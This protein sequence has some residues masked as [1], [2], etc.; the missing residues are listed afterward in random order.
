MYSW[1]NSAC[2][3]VTAWC[4]CHSYLELPVWLSQGDRE[5]PSNPL[6]SPAFSGTRVTLQMLFATRRRRF[7]TMFL[8]T[9]CFTCMRMWNLCSS[10]ACVHF[11][12]N[13]PFF[14]HL[15]NFTLILWMFSSQCLQVSRSSR[16]L[17][18]GGHKYCFDITN[19]PRIQAQAIFTLW[20]VKGKYYSAQWSST[21]GGKSP[22]WSTADVGG[23]EKSFGKT[24]RLSWRERELFISPNMCGANCSSG[25]LMVTLSGVF[26]LPSASGSEETSAH[27]L[28]VFMMHTRWD[29][30]KN[31]NSNNY[32]CIRVCWRIHKSPRS[33]GEFA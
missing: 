15:D 22:E 1:K 28:R 17:D 5:S 23:K 21:R 20:A 16:L 25:C 8:N 6:G 27:T 18:S 31:N 14:F 19:V 3:P 32:S 11:S 7:C 9:P 12:C 30:L 13:S 2:S 29:M 10:A 33:T 26:L 4:W 24:R